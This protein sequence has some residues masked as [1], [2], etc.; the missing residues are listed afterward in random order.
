MSAVAATRFAG[1]AEDEEVIFERFAVVCASVRGLIRG[2]KNG[3]VTPVPPSP[4]NSGWWGRWLGGRATNISSTLLGVNGRKGGL[5]D[6]YRL[7]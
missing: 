7:L 6:A 3:L 2:A 1:W 4:G 5:A